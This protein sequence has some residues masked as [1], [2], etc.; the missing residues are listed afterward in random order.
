MDLSIQ[1]KG[2]PEVDERHT[3]KDTAVALG[4][5]IYQALGNKCGTERYGCALPMDDCFCRACLDPG[6]RPWL[7]R[8]TEFKREKVGEVPTEMSLYFFRS[9]NDT[10]KVNLNVKAEG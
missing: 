10:A 5:C 7:V 9:P 8:D 4:D 1:V 3:I 2:D 6:G